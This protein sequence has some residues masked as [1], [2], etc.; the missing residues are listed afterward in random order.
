MLLEK[1]VGDPARAR[2]LRSRRPADPAA[3]ESVPRGVAPH[4]RRPRSGGGGRSRA[5]GRQLRNRRFVARCWTHRRAAL[6]PVV[7]GALALFVIRWWARCGPPH[8]HGRSHGDTPRDPAVIAAIGRKRRHARS[9]TPSGA[10]TE[11]RLRNIPGAHQC[12][13]AHPEAD[14]DTQMIET[15]L[16]AE[17]SDTTA[18]PDPRTT[19]AKPPRRRRDRARPSRVH[20]QEVERTSVVGSLP[21][22]DCTAP[23]RLQSSDPVCTTRLESSTTCCGRGCAACSCRCSI[24]ASASKNESAGQPSRRCESREPR[25]GRQ[26]AVC[27]DEPWLKSAAPTPWAGSVAPL[28]SELVVAS[29]RRHRCCVEPGRPSSAR[30]RA[31]CGVCTRGGLHLAEL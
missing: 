12:Y 21:A 28:E 15:V 14:R 25:A 29:N 11:L 27:S 3:P 19:S 6:T 5:G 20:D 22:L 31:G 7:A 13:K 8:G 4:D 17:I 9:G 30:G 24:S 10:D 18:L 16:A 1:R 26:R 23:A 2:R